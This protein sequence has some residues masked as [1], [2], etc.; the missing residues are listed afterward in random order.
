MC[1]VIERINKSEYKNLYNPE[2]VWMPKDG[3]GAGNNWASGF[4]QGEK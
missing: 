2:N 3:G 1:A 4:A